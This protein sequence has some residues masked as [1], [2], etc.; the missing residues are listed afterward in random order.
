MA[1]SP[2]GGGGVVLDPK[3]TE[4][5]QSFEKLFHFDIS[6]D[7]AKARGI[8]ERVYV[9]FEHDSEPLAFRFYRS[10]RR[11]MLKRFGI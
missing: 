3:E 2:E 6:L 1:L 5:P 9:R 10:I 11:V 4:K 8:G 7:Q